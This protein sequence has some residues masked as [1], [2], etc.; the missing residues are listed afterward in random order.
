MSKLQVKCVLFEKEGETTHLVLHLNFESVQPPPPP[1]P[2]LG[3]RDPQLYICTTESI[4]TGVDYRRETE[5]S[6]REIILQ[7]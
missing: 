7:R 2:I 4:K 5:K 6:E 1:L 3:A